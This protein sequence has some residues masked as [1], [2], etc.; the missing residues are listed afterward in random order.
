MSSFHPYTSLRKRLDSLVK[1]LNGPDA[2]SVEPIHHARVAT[3]RLR[4]LLPLLPLEPA[5]TRHFGRRLRKLG[6]QLG[7]V[8]DLDVLLLLTQE[9]AGASG[10]PATALEGVITAAR[11]ARTAALERLW[12]K[13]PAN[14]LKR[15]L[16]RLESACETLN[17][18]DASGDRSGRM[19]D[20]ARH[21]IVELRLARRAEGV[22]TAIASAGT[23]YCP[24]RLHQ[25]RIA[26]KKLRYA[27]EL[28]ADTNDQYSA[29][30]AV[31]KVAQNALGRLHDV[32]GLLHKVREEQASLQTRSLRARRQLDELAN[33]LQ[34]D[35][36]QMHAR[37]MRDRIQL[38]AIASRMSSDRRDPRLS[39]RAG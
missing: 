11:Q 29:E 39:R 30:I 8:R 25:V 33:T 3:R 26:V 37:Y 27:A 21:S 6:K 7:T 28:V 14:R 4:E 16:R 12:D 31:L 20:R 35:C 1:E 32:E 2:G 9:L 22:R 5:L 24:N 36:R 34:R 38:T 15:L 18:T 17:A 13:W 10:Y 19:A 23:V